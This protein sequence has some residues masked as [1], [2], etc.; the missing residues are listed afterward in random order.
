M[1]TRARL[2]SKGY[3]GPV[4]C[5]SCPHANEDIRQIMCACP[6]A[7]SI[8]SQEPFKLTI[9]MSHVFDFEEWML[10]QALVLSSEKFE[11]LLMIIWGLWKNRNDTFWSQKSQ[12]AA[13]ILCGAMAWYHEFSAANGAT[14][15]RNKTVNRPK[16]NW[17]NP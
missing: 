7:H 5:V 11:K 10:E 12:S 13:D 16:W 14:S 15:S 4:Q 2:T 17:R 8:I 3:E 6:V 9:P 1:P